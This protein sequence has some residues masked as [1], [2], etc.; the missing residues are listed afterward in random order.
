MWS[1]IEDER[2][3]CP[4]SHVWLHGGGRDLLAVGGPVE[5]RCTSANAQVCCHTAVGLHRAGQAQRQ[6]GSQPGV[7][8]ACVCLQVG[9]AEP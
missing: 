6:H 9:G 3:V 7:G 1:L 5:Q 4:A 8:C 2:G